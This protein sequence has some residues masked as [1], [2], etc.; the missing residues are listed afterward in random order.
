MYLWSGLWDGSDGVARFGDWRKN[1]VYVCQEPLNQR[2]LTYTTHRRQDCH[3]CPLPSDGHV[4][5]AYQ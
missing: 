3:S 1:F 5:S 4:A 2:Q